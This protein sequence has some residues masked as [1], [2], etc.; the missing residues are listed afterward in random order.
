MK[1]VTESIEDKDDVKDTNCG[2][3]KAKEGIYAE[4]ANKE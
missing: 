1:K 3:E 4:I 2:D